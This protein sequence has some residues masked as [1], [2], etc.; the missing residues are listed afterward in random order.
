[1]EM[2]S[3]QKWMLEY[4]SNLPFFMAH[5]LKIEG[6]ELQMY[7]ILKSQFLACLQVQGLGRTLTKK[8]LWRKIVPKRS[9]LIHSNGSQTAAKTLQHS[10]PLKASTSK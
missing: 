9:A 6:C 5:I 2:G 3:Q 10:Y 7:F 1:M 8:I 4:P